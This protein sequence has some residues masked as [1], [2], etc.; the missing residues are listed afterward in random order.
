M[1]LVRPWAIDLVNGYVLCNTKSLPYTSYKTNLGHIKPSYILYGYT[2][3]SSAQYIDIYNIA[4]TQWSYKWTR[5][6]SLLE[7]ELLTC[8]SIFSFLFSVLKII[9]C[10]IV[11]SLSVIVFS[12]LWPSMIYGFLLPRWYPKTFLKTFLIS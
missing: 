11:L 3:D 6:V 9:D 2:L 7:Q 8:C 12:D 1:N 5:H 10:L 4:V